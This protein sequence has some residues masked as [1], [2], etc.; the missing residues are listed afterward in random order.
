VSS[1]GRNSRRCETYSQLWSSE[2]QNL[3]LMFL[4]SLS[5][6]SEH[7]T[8]QGATRRKQSDALIVIQENDCNL[9]NEEPFLKKGK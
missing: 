2:E 1:V 5:Q 6:R 4:G 3:K 9:S 7:V 8:P